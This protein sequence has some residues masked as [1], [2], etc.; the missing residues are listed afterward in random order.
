MC[1]QDVLDTAVGEW[2][3]VP[4]GEL[5]ALSALH[6]PPT[7]QILVPAFYVHS[8]AFFQV[9]VLLNGSGCIQ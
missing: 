1:A 9:N 5:G 3:L 2:V 4:S 8:Q 6:W 7:L